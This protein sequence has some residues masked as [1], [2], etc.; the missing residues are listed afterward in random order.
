M[1]Q[2]M[3]STV[4]LGA[5]VLFG[6][7]GAQDGPKPTC[8]H[9]P[10]TYIP[11]DEIQAYLKRVPPETGVSDQQVRALDVGKTNVDIG[12]VYRGKLSGGSPNVAEHDHVSEVYHIIDGTATLV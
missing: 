2:E 8:N 9:C 10:A 7:Q 1:R 3:L 12:I 11:N 6:A 5:F 4:L